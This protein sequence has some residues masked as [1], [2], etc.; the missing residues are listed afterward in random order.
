MS[1]LN[2][3]RKLLL[4]TVIPMLLITSAAIGIVI[5]LQTDTLQKNITSYQHTLTEERKNNIKDTSLVAKAVIEDIVSRLGTT[6]EAKEAALHALRKALFSDNDAG[7]FFLF[8]ENN[9]YI[10]H[11]LHS[12][13]VGQSGADLT[14]PNGVKITLNLQQQAQKGGGFIEYIY[15]K[16]GS[17]TPK[18]KISYSSPIAGSNWFLGSGL[19]IDDIEIGRASC[20]ERV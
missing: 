20:R 6:E 10:A 16:E 14:D 19:Y 1:T 12:Y 5:V 13:L 9:N 17:S 15:D 4:I 7:Y 8:D 2:I 18:P 11:G 3:K